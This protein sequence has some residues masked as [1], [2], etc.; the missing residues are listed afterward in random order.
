[1]SKQVVK[2]LTTDDV[3]NSTWSETDEVK[4]V[5]LP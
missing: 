1:M 5:F 4:S 3:G 2:T